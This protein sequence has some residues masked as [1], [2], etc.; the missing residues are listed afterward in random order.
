VTR[1]DEWWLTALFGF[2]ALGVLGW[3]LVVGHLWVPGSWANAIELAGWVLIAV[4]LFGVVVL[5]LGDVAVS[6]VRWLHN[7]T[8]SWEAMRN[9]GEVCVLVA[10]LMTPPYFAEQ[11]YG[12]NWWFA[13]AITA[14]I[15]LPLAWKPLRLKWPW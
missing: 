1:W 15:V 9:F 11:W 13:A 8:L 14:M 10:L 7:P 4:K 2:F 6:I 3:L 12:F 5:V